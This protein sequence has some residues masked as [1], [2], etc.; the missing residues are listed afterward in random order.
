[1]KKIFALLLVY[2]AIFWSCDP[3]AHSIDKKESLEKED[4]KVIST[5][6]LYEIQVPKYMKEMKS[7]HEEASL[8]YANIFKEVYIL[9]LEENKQNF[10]DN[11]S[12]YG[13]YD[14]EKSVL[15]NYEE[16]Q[17]ASFKETIE[18]IKIVPK[19]N[20]QINDLEARQSL[21]NG[22]VEDIK[23]SYLLTV[24]EGN[25]NIYMLMSWT[26]PSRMKKYKNTFEY[27]HNSFQLK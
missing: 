7:L 11:L 27:M 14:K 16:I 23:I 8:R 6:N 4:Y 18:D 24:I 12:V 20:I 3:I 10:I 1:M 25:E 17:L 9:V 21:M 5:S 13:L 22:K 19:G 15:D 2:L 26:L